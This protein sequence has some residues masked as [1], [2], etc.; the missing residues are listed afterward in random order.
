MQYAGFGLFALALVGLAWW[1]SRLMTSS[2][3]ND[4]ATHGGGLDDMNRDAG[5]QRQLEFPSVLPQPRMLPADQQAKHAAL[6]AV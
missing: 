2:K 6:L 5:D 4:G 1:V 3:R